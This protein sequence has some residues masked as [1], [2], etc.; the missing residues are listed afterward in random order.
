MN[1]TLTSA[2][3]GRSRQSRASSY[4]VPWGPALGL[5]QAG[6]GCMRW[7][8]RETRRF[9]RVVTFQHLTAS[10][11]TPVAQTRASWACLGYGLRRESY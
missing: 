3:G 11:F 8:T 9:A 2:G 1:R 5:G 7:L 4:S 6:G 10:S